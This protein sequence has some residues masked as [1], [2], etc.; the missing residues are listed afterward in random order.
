LNQND[1]H[2]PPV[3]KQKWKPTS[4]ITGRLDAFDTH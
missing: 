1:V 4:V 3:H 2:Q